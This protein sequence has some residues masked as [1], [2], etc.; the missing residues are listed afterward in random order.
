[1]EKISGIIP[2]SARTKVAD[3]SVSQPARPG[4]PLL[5]RP[6]GKNSLGD[7]ITLS[8]ELE[9]LRQTGQ[10]PEPE[11]TPVYKQPAEAKKLKVIQE[12]N[13][14]FFTDPKELAREENI[15]KSEET[16]KKTES[17]EG[18]FFVERELKPQDPV[19]PKA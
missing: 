6:M 1:M 14:K 3:I 2:A 15:P 12:L 19:T 11:M 8:K 7:R 13:E 18:L 17:N 9:E 16:L 10:F 5:G 4:A